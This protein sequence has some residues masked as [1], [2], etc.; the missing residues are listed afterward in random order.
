MVQRGL[1]VSLTVTVVSLAK[2]AEPIEMSF[3]AWT[4]VGPAKH[5]L[6]GGAHWRN[7]AN[8]IEPSMC[9]GDAAFLSDYFDMLSNIPGNPGNLLEIYK[10][11][12]R[13]SGLVC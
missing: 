9:G 1:S 7:L 8:A 12:W 4:R 11:S 6:D 13:F 3:G 10:V 2:T 5:V